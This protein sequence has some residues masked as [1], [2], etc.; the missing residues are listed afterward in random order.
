MLRLHDVK[1][2][3]VNWRQMPVSQRQHLCRRRRRMLCTDPR[4]R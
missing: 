2:V 1:L 4:R 3:R